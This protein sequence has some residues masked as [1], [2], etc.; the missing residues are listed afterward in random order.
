LHGNIFQ[1]GFGKSL[2][3]NTNLCFRAAKFTAWPA[4]PSK[5]LLVSNIGKPAVQ[6]AAAWLPVSVAEFAL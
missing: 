2:I 5:N 6:A 4:H 3:E 1:F